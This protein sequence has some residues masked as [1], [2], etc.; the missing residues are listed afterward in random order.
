MAKGKGKSPGAGAGGKPKHSND[1]N[2]PSKSV[3][4]QRDAA[5]VRPRRR[6]RRGRV[7]FPRRDAPPR[8]QPLRPRQIA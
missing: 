1:A 5:T 8:A 6:A 7:T 4:G 3:G 2:R